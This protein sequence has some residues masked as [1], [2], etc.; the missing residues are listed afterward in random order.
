M[1]VW[2]DEGFDTN[3][4]SKYWKI[5]NDRNKDRDFKN[6]VYALE[7]DG[8]FENRKAAICILL[9][10]SEREQTYL[11]ICSIRLEISVVR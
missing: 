10:F 6:A 1:S 7:N 4:I 9:N 3:S 5:I 8:N 2:A 11:M